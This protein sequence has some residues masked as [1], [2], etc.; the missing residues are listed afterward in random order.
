MSPTAT[1]PSI[2]AGAA[3]V[4]DLLLGRF[5]ERA[6]DVGIQAELRVHRPQQ[7]HHR[8]LAA[9]VDADGDAVLLG[10]VDF[11][12][13][14]ALGNHAAAE[15]P[16]LARFHFGDEIDTGAAMQLAHHDAFGAVDDELAAAE[17]DRQVAEVDFFLDRLLF[18]EPQPNAERPAV[19]QTQLAAF[20][21]L[22]ARLAQLVAQIRERQLLVVAFDREDFAQYAFQAFVLALVGRAFRIA[23]T[24]RSSWSGSR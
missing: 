23:E 19:G 6:E 13:A 5:V 20:I 7:R 1:L 8:K 21:R 12:P 2:L 17:H 18:V 15:Q 9:L 10:R 24:A 22:V 16:A 14:S 3:A 4:G 11:D